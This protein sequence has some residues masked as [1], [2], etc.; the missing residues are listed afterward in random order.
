MHYNF[1][2]KVSLSNHQ[3]DYCKLS[4]NHKILA[5]IK[6]RMGVGLRGI[7]FLYWG[8][9]GGKIVGPL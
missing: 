9:G 4:V 7:T 8:G 6:P 1:L 3:N 5:D 2:I